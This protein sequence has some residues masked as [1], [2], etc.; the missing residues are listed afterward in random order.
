MK[1][2]FRSFILSLTQPTYYKDVLQ[3]RLRFSFKYYIVLSSLLLL[4]STIAGTINY[5][6]SI[7]NDLTVTAKEAVQNF[8]SDLV[9]TISPDGITANKDF[10]LIAQMP[11]ML[12]RGNEQFKNL[13]VI[14]PK[15]EIGALEKYSALILVNNSYVIVGNGDS[16]QTTSL[17]DFPE[18]RVDYPTMQRISQTFLAVAKAATLYTAGFFAFTGF[19]NFF[20]WRLIYLA[21]FAFGLR[22]VFKSTVGTFTKAFQVSLHSVTLPFLISTTLE[23]AVIKAPFSGWFMVVHA[24]FSFY[25][26]SRL[27][28]LPQN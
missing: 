24:I 18:L 21:I 10:P 26:L 4:I 5:A 19:F 3:A 12:A 27:E 14:D 2:F 13:V 8:P 15:G 17:K 16:V 20:L 25:I 7:K 11:S 28:K 9:L 6:A 22:L 1:T 23:A